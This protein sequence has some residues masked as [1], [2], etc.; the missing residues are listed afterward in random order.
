MDS[1]TS[2]FSWV[3]SIPAPQIGLPG[4]NHMVTHS[5]FAEGHGYRTTLPSA[6][7]RVTT[8]KLA[9]E[10]EFGVVILHR[11]RNQVAKPGTVFFSRAFQEV[12]SQKELYSER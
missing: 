4:L 10:E 1:P 11:Q 3:N 8:L 12:L 2:L 5:Q 6:D 7:W 9:S